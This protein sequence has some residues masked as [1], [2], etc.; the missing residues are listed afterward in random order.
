MWY[1]INSWMA[2]L[3]FA[4]LSVIFSAKTFAEVREPVE[5]D[6]ADQLRVV[7][8][9]DD[10]EVAIQRQDWSGARRFFA[11]TLTVDFSAVVGGEAVTMTADDFV[12]SRRVSDA[13]STVSGIA[14]GNHQVLVNGAEAVVLSKG[15]LAGFLSAKGEQK[16]ANSQGSFRHT[17]KRTPQ[18]WKVTHVEFTS[19]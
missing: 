18:G 8:V 6:F 17:L 15:S 14:Y 1:Q 5:N 10:I 2:I 7:R 13:R 9:V 19:L 12:A 16:P 3:A 4:V 11:D